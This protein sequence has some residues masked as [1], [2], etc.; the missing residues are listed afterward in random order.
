MHKDTCILMLAEFSAGN[1]GVN[2]NKVDAVEWP[3]CCSCVIAHV[4]CLSDNLL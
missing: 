4:Q 3:L 2:L 1:L